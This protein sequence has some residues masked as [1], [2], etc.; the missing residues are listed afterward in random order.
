M[1]PCAARSTPPTSAGSIRRPRRCSCVLLVA[2]AC[3]VFRHSGAHR[4]TSS[5]RG[6]AEG[7][8]SGLSK[9]ACAFLSLRDSG[10]D[11]SHRPGITCRAG[12]RPE[13]RVKLLL[14][15]GTGTACSILRR[16]IITVPQ[17]AWAHAETGIF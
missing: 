12:G 17:S 3:Y 16:V 6:E 13:R 10:F 2:E 9:L 5:F 15:F 1:P 14:A 4:H 8:E 7:L 11:A